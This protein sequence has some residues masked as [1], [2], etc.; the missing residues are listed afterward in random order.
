[1][2]K[3]AVAVLACGLVLAG[4]SSSP[5]AQA[6]ALAE[7]CNVFKSHYTLKQIEMSATWGQ[8]SGDAEIA[9]EAERLQTDL[10]E[11]QGGVS[12]AVEVFMMTERCIQLGALPKSDLPTTP[13]TP[14]TPTS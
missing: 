14:T 5:S 3:L 12:A 11:P 9:R 7:T 6:R 1:V 2:R 13:T 8:K 10:R 4:C